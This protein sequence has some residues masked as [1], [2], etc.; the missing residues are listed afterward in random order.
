VHRRTVRQALESAVPLPRKP[1]PRRPKPA[2][3]AY[4][5][6]IDS[7]LLADRLVPCKQRHTALGDVITPRGNPQ[8]W[9]TRIDSPLSWHQIKP[10]WHRLDRNGSAQDRTGIKVK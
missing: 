10:S 1:Y 5:G 7:W 6:V 3:D 4:A 2:I 9:R 8:H